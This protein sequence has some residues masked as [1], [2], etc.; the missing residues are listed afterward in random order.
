L[1]KY[2]LLLG[3]NIGN[4]INVINK[5]IEEIENNVGV[6]LN[7]SSFYISEPWGFSSNNMFYNIAIEIASLLKPEDLLEYI[8]NIELANG[9]IKNET[10]WS[11]RIIDIDILFIDNMIINTPNLTV[12]HKLL[13]K[14]MF[15]LKPLSQ[16]AG[17][18]I[19]PIFNQNIN[20]LL[21]ECDDKSN[22]KKLITPNI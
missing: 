16:I 11:D 4:S 19:H 7:R 2:Y 3:S 22:V 13:H 9:R 1:K 17:E 8:K 14:R 5:C 20:S 15:V 10:Q 12:P 18:L 6:I 21:K